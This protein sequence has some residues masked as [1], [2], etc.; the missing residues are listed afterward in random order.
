[1]TTLSPLDATSSSSVP[2]VD[3]LTAGMRAELDALRSAARRTARRPAAA[4]A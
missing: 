4:P 3:E 1:V 2:D